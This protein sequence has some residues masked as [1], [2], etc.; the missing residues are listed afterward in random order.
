MTLSD[1]PNDWQRA[2]CVVAHPDDLEYGTAAAVAHWTAQGKQ[3]TYLLVTRGEAGIATM[4][5]E[6]AAGV[7]E[8]E[9][10]DSAAV[11]G[12]DQVHFLD[13]FADGVV[14]PTL[15]LRRE[16]AR[17]VRMH[18]P[19]VVITL[20]HAESFPGGGLNQADHRVVGLTTI[21]AV[22][23]AGNRWIFPELIDDGLTPWEGVRWIAVASGHG[24]THEVDVTSTFE[25]AV[26]SLEAHAEYN[27]ALPDTFPA[28]R[29]LLTGILGDADSAGA[30]GE[31][32]RF[33][34]V[35][36][37]HGR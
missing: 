2:L 26:A 36:Q 28:P 30:D 37:L 35:A 9:E 31:P 17:H 20:T 33:R 25:A 21:D 23:A 6:Q 8:R 11:V 24:A 3:V 22:A 18:Q 34:W 19:E 32:T 14:E 29:Q 16:I 27:A 1:F 5:P 4:P 12:V 13:G 10:R 7:R 15:E